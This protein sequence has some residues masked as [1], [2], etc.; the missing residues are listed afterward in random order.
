MRR[1]VQFKRLGV[2]ALQRLLVELFDLI[3]E[4]LQILM[5]LFY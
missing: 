5:L 1:R 2:Q 4:D 3:G